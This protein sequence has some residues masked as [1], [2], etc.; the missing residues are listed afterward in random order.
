MPAPS[1]PVPTSPDPG[2]THEDEA[3]AAMLRHHGDDGQEESASADESTVDP[4]PGTAPAE[5]PPAP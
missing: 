4:E 3:D 2:A 1:Y 5:P